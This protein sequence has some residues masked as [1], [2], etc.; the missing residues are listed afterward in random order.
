MNATHLALN[1]GL[2]YVEGKIQLYG[3]VID[4]AWCVGEDGI[5]IDPTLTT[6]PDGTMHCVGNYFGIPFITAY[7]Q[8][9]CLKNKVYGLLDGYGSRKT[10]PKLIELGLEDG[11]QWLLGGKR[12]KKA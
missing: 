6:G 2:T 5:V 7:V 3:V 1:E 12:R 8:K 10:L 9:A 4:H 11:Q